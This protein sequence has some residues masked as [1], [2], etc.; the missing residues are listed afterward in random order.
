MVRTTCSEVRFSA[1]IIGSN[2]WCYIPGDA[3]VQVMLQFAHLDWVCQVIGVD[4][5]LIP[6]MGRQHCEKR[7]ML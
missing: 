1:M 4:A 5:Q 7:E 2:Q 3:P 6:C